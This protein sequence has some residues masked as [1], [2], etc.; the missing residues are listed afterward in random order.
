MKKIILAFAFLG[1]SF[2]GL[3]YAALTA[4][5]WLQ[6]VQFTLEKNMNNNAPVKVHVLVVYDDGLLKQLKKMPAV[7]YFKQSEGIKKDYAG[8][9]D[10]FVA[11]IVPGQKNDPLKIE[12]TNTNGLE[13]L[14][15]AR[16]ATP[17]AHRASVGT[18]RI[19][20]VDLQEKDFKLVT[21]K[22]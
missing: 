22:P 19:V 1:A 17:G 12:P 21:I 5:V 2:A 3:S 20:Q 6:E 16:Y 4:A 9:L 7:D 13:A 8:K 11:E 15:F 18:D 14:V 10:V